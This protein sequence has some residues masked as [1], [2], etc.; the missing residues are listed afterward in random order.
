ME[1]QELE[2]RELILAAKIK[3][4]N[5][6]IKWIVLGAFLFTLLAT[7]LSGITLFSRYLDKVKIRK[8][9]GVTVK[10][11]LPET[12]APLP[13]MYPPVSNW[14]TPSSPSAENSTVT[15]V[16][17]KFT[18]SKHKIKARPRYKYRQ[19]RKYRVAPKTTS[20]Y[21][22]PG[23]IKISDEWYFNPKAISPNN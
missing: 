5:E 19:A 4:T 3:T 10:V 17:P 7:T 8:Q 21:I 23:Y 18:A 16:I 2:V 12:K 11:E 6:K 20:E 1:A 15:N 22:P 14:A 9:D 13:F